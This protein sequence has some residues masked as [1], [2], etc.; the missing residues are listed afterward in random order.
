MRRASATLFMDSGYSAG[1]R[2]HS[3]R[4]SAQGEPR[5]R[6]WS[7][8]TRF[9]VPPPGPNEQDPMKSFFQRVFEGLKPTPPGEPERLAIRE[10]VTRRD[11]RI[12]THFT[13]LTNLPGILDRG[14]VPAKTLRAIPE[15]GAAFNDDARIDGYEDANCLGVSFPNYR[16]FYRLRRTLGGN[17]VV[18]AISPDVLTEFE[19]LY[20]NTNAAHSSELVRSRDVRKTPGAFEQMFGESTRCTAPGGRNALELPPAV[21]TDPQAEILVRGTIPLK[22]FVGILVESNVVLEQVRTLLAARGLSIHHEVNQHA[23]NPR[24]DSRYW[25]SPPPATEGSAP[26]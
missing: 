7:A 20:C 1:T 22:H 10:I 9:I 2:V 16:M 17:W 19:C 21:P 18:L 24:K 23:F 4:R 13:R 14:L 6:R 26:I 3:T 15:H 8:F 25:K 11:I 5:E 12:L